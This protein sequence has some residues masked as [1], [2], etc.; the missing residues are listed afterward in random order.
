MSIRVST[1][2]HRGTNA[3]DRNHRPVLI[4]LMEDWSGGLAQTTRSRTTVEV[5]ITFPRAKKVRLLPSDLW[6]LINPII[7]VCGARGPE[8]NFFM[9]IA[10]RV[11]RTLGNLLRDRDPD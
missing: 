1:S 8:L 10:S 6:F 3:L 11:F 7:Y 4:V 2:N 5:Y 9:R